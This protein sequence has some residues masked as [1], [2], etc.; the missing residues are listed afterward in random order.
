MH[1]I[2][3]FTIFCAV[4]DGL[5]ISEKQVQLALQRIRN[6]RTVI[7]IAHRLSTIKDA[8]IIHVMEHG[9]IVESGQHEALLSA[10]GLYYKMNNQ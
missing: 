3:K 9:N 4:I 8:D 1:L 2:V 10:N 5:D 7:V 6:G